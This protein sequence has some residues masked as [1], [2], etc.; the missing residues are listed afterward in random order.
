MPYFSK[1]ISMKAI[2]LCA[3]LLPSLALSSRIEQKRAG[4]NADLC[5]RA[6]NPTSRITAASKDCSAFFALE[7]AAT[8]VPTYASACSGSQRFSSACSCIGV[9]SPAATTTSSSTTASQAVAPAA[10]SPTS[11]STFVSI[12]TVLTTATSTVFSTASEISSVTATTT[13]VLT[14][15][16]TTTTTVQATYTQGVNSNGQQ[17]S[18]YGVYVDSAGPFNG[19]FIDVLNGAVTLTSQMNKATIL[20]VDPSSGTVT[21]AKYQDPDNVVT[22]SG[23]APYWSASAGYS[24]YG[25]PIN[26]G[27]D[28]H[29][30]CSATTTST[31]APSIFFGSF[32]CTMPETGSPAHILANNDPARPGS[33]IATADAGPEIYNPTYWTELTF[34]FI[35]VCDY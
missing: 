14:V 3:A 28:F 30:A 1:M 16:T 24:Q 19:W 21:V 31:L 12:I 29:F 23:S 33:L 10:G 27:S 15:A 5:L 9:T 26:L 22:T 4:C 20:N 7:G 11:T 6:I 2:A 17:C 25:T 34:K 8:A 18:T 32:S 13:T 35:S